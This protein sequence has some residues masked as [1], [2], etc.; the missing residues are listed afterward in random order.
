[1]LAQHLFT[2]PLFDAM[3]HDQ[4]FTAQNPVSRAMQGIWTS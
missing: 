3:F 1:M 2:K 4:E